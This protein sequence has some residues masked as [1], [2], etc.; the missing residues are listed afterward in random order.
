MVGFCFSAQGLRRLRKQR[1]GCRFSAQCPGAL[2]EW[3]KL[4]LKAYIKPYST[5]IVMTYYP[6][7]GNWPSGVLPGLVRRVTAGKVGIV[8]RT[9]K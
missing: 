5:R 7:L 6:L 3:V 9:L 8:S 1:V 2:V 4:L